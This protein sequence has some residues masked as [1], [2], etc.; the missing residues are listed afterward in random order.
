[1]KTSKILFSGSEYFFLNKKLVKAF[2][3]ETILVLSQLIEIEEYSN[4]L[5]EKKYFL[6]ELNDVENRTN[7]S[8]TKIK[9]AINKL[10]KI[11][12]IDVVV[13]KK[14]KLYV[15]VLQINIINYL[16]K[17]NILTDLEKQKKQ[18]KQAFPKNTK[19]K[20][21]RVD[22]LKN[23][24]LALGD[25]TNQSEIMF[26]YYESKG[27]KVGKSPMKCWKSAARNWLRRIKHENVEF[28][29]YYDKEIEKKIGNDHNKLS[30]YHQHLRKMGWSS[31]YSPT[32]GTTWI[33]K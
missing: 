12:F 3:I 31:L 25:K 9:N 16:T 27:W 8:I 5:I 30:R 1:M 6:S 20:K 24:F 15:K 13:K 17:K 28:P 4:E 7:L 26:D 10:Y 11:K 19:F 18:K 22:D 32:A 21:P 2:G 29:D 23:Y 14:D 33:K